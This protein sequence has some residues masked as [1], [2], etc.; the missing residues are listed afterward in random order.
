MAMILLVD[1][2]PKFKFIVDKLNEKLRLGFEINIAINV[3]YAIDLLIELEREGILPQAI[4][5]DLS[6]DENSSGFDS[7]G[8][9]FLEVYRDMG[10]EDKPIK[11]WV[12]TNSASIKD[13]E[14]IAGIDFVEDLVEK[15]GIKDFMTLL[16]K[17]LK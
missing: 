6:F 15:D 17:K 11:I 1:D 12:L 16:K 5:L 9:D 7:S 13:K 8:Y 4:L 10:W 3:S 2:D 14:I